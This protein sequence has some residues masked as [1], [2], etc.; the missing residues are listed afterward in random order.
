MVPTPLPSCL[1]P[2]IQHHIS[3]TI[4]H[5]FFK[6]GADVRN[7]EHSRTVSF[8][9]KNSLSLL[10]FYKAVWA[11]ILR[12]FA[13]TNDVYFGVAEA[14]HTRRRVSSVR[15][16]NAQEYSQTQSWCHVHL[17]ETD[18]VLEILERLESDPR[19]GCPA[20]GLKL[21]L[22][23]FNTEIHL[24]EGDVSE[25]MDENGGYLVRRVQNFK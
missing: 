9:A 24:L 17:S 25:Y 11:L 7:T 16:D 3:P 12:Q 18:T 22:A 19:R 2:V 1:F 13:N 4:G 5:S 20:E 23:S 21:T 6:V 8:C 15:V 14:S 10:T